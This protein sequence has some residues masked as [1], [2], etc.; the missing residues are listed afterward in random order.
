M[1]RPN[2]LLIT[3]DDMNWNTV[4]AYGCKTPECTPNIDALAADGVCFNYGHVTIA[5]CQPSRG[6]L[7]TGRYPHK[8]GQEGFHYID[9]RD[10]PLLPEELRKEGYLNGIL[11]KVGHS[12]PKQ[13]FKWDY[14]EDMPELGWGR[15]AEIY[16]GCTVEFLE[17]AHT[18]DKPFFLMANAHDP[19]RPFHGNDASLYGK[20]GITY[21]VPSR[22]YA[23]E[24]VEVPGFLPDIPDVRRE[25]AEYASSVRRCDDVV[26][27]IIAALK[28]TGAYDNT[29]IMFLSDNGMAFPFSKTNCYLHSTKTPWIVC[30]PGRATAG[31]VDDEHFISGIDFMPTA[32]EAAGATCPVGVDGASFLSV[33]EGIGDSSRGR[34]FTQFHENFAQDRYPMRCVQDRQ[35]GYIFSPWSDGKRA[36]RNESQAGR[37]FKA[38]Q[39]AAVS[40]SWIADRVELFEHRVVEELYDFANDP[41]ALNNLVD[42]PAHSE[43]L[44][45]LRGELEDWM[46]QN[47]DSALESFRKRDCRESLAAF[48]VEQELHSVRLNEERMRQ[49][50]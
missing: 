9:G 33:L 10:V 11:G 46:V 19:H 48:M 27:L 29:L 15:N 16:H 17:M 13:A 24:E 3:A 44:E 40:D 43:A 39:A 42:S 4:G 49:K 14:S 12:T 47:E 1:K 32:L 45:R 21:P 22:V 5:V 34:V 23:P 30:W 18:Q 2:I 50:H 37:T 20:E 41:D 35:Y 31:T 36:F 7:M 38:M 6:A 25:I 28:E 26:G 8:S